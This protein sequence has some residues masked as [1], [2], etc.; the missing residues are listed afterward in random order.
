MSII[1]PIKTMLL[2]AGLLLAVQPS[3]AQNIIR[4]KIAGPN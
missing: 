2:G 1:K 3:G 4:P